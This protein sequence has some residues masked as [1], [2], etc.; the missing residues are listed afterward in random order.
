[1]LSRVRTLGVA[2]L[3]SLAA[4]RAF[5]LLDIVDI[6]KSDSLLWFSTKARQV[7]FR[8]VEESRDKICADWIKVIDIAITGVII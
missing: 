7:C 4:T 1:M 2:V 5:P 8:I 6:L 3:G